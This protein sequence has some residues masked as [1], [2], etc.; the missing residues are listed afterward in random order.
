MNDISRP[1]FSLVSALSLLTVYHRPYDVFLLFPGILYVYIHATR[2]GNR[3]V[4]KI[5]ATFVIVIVFVLTLPIDISTRISSM[6]PILLDNYL[7]RVI[8]PVNAWASV[9]V[10]AVLLWL[11]I[12]ESKSLE[13]R[14]LSVERNWS[15]HGNQEYIFC[16]FVSLLK[17]LRHN[18]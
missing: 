10:F 16:V 4:Q 2:I 18:K 17:F 8:A 11:K 7:W 14:S 6:Y 1:N 15:L 12:H 5:W 9:A 13:R 3:R